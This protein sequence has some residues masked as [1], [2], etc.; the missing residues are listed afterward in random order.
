M[1]NRLFRIS[2]LL[3]IVVLLTLFP[4]Q[5][6]TVSAHGGVI[7]DG[8]TTEHYEWIA[9]A[10]PFPVTP[11][12]T[13]LTVL[14][15]DINTYAP[16]DGLIPTLELAPPDAPRPCCSGDNTLGPLAL[17][18]DPVLY[19]GD[20]SNIT[21]LLQ[22]GTWQGKFT[23]DES[24]P[25]GPGEEVEIFFEID[26]R[27]AVAGE[28]RP[29][30]IQADIVALTATAVASGVE[31]NPA[32]VAQSAEQTGYPIPQVTPQKFQAPATSTAYP[33]PESSEATDQVEG[34]EPIAGADAAPDV[35]TPD[36]ATSSTAESANSGP[37][38]ASEN[39]WLLA[40]LALVPI[41][42][43]VVWLAVSN[44]NSAD[45]LSE[46]EDDDGDGDE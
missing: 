33:A 13:I 28:V 2:S 15:Y 25:I 36:G 3:A 40:A 18:V 20:Y 31:Q 23:I 12:E 46:D 11:G 10:S 39:I 14:I 42:L 7:I 1:I 34:P 4:W 32:A 5:T 41:F 35:Q 24:D 26:V 27:E 43:I 30:P 29:T 45:E 22:E 16:I 44:N 19:P 8:G 6:Q 17:L 37:S 9:M 38:W 21:L